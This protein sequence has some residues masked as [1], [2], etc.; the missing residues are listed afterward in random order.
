M[1]NEAFFHAVR[2]VVLVL[3]QALIFNHINF[4]G[5]IN[6]YPYIL[7]M[8]LLPFS[9][10][11]TSVL[12]LSFFLGLAVDVFS[13]G[14]GVNTIAC[15]I[16]G[17]VRPLYLK[18]AFGIGI[19]YNT[20]KLQEVSFDKKIIYLILLILTHHFILFSLEIFSFTHM[21]TILRK[22]FYSGVFT[23]VVSILF[24]SI[25]NRKRS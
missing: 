17:Y 6:P 14:G 10:S 9:I 3:A 23:L 8:A 13:D 11:K 15:L 18:A 4:L 19:E 5:Y 12:V 2:F 1:N 22:M 24:I 25:F 16:T 21:G 20:V 7:F